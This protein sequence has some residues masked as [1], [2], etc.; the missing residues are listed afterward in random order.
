MA[1]DP[2]LRVEHG[3]V[4]V[5]VGEAGGQVLGR[6]PLHL[7]QDVAG[8]GEVQ[9]GERPGAQDGAGIEDLEQVE[10]DVA[11]VALVVPHVRLS[12]LLRVLTRRLPASSVQ[13]A[14]DW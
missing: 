9:L 12:W 2:G 5:G 7:G 13:D 4:A 1:T 10:L 8:G 6:Q 11:Q 3:R 14:T